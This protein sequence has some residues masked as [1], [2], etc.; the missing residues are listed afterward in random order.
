MHMHRLRYQ[1]WSI[2]HFPENT[3]PKEGVA[4]SM[5]TH[6]LS[7]SSSRILFRQFWLSRINFM[8]GRESVF[9]QLR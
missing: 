4:D 7:W 8:E 1:R 6:S 9:L 5:M 3:D 2:F